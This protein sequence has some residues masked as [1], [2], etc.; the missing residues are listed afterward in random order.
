MDLL[1]I[2]SHI[3]TIVGGGI[4]GYF[5]RRPMDRA[6]IAEKDAS[7]DEKR[8]S[9]VKLL[10]DASESMARQLKAF[11]AE[12]PLWKKKFD[13]ETARADAAEMY[14]NRARRIQEQ[15]AIISEHLSHISYMKEPDEPESKLERRFR[16]IKEACAIIEQM[17]LPDRDTL[18]LQ[19]HTPAP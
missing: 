14:N 18:V 11:E 9:A 19:V 16:E 1:T 2:I 6:T 15:A 7:A 10:A 3:V 17:Q 4:V 12:V 13:D 8:A 5:S